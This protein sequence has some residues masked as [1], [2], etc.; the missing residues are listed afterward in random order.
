MEATAMDLRYH[1]KDIFK[2]LD[3]NEPVDLLYRGKLKGTIV[4]KQSKKPKMDMRDHPAFGI[5]ADD[6]RSVEE[7]MHELRKG[8]YDDLR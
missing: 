3:R 8:R 5:M 7:I 4:P 2:A 1:L 6:P